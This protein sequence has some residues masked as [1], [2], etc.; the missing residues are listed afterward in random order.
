MSGGPAPHEPVESDRADADE[1]PVPT[2]H[3]D[4]AALI[5][6]LADPVFV[7][8]T[9]GRLRFL[10]AAVGAVLG[11]EP[12]E[13]IGRSVGEVVHQDDLALVVSSLG[14]VQGKPTGT[15][16]EVRVRNAA[17][18]WQWLEV[19]GADRTGVP[20]VDGVVCVARDLTQ[21]RM[22]EVAAGDVTRFQQVVQHAPSITLLLDG[23]GVV[24]STNGAFTR[25]LGHD[26]SLVVGQRLAVFAEPPNDV[27]LQGTIDACA[28]TGDSATVEVPMCRS[29]PRAE[30]VPVR[31][32]IIDLL[33][34]PVVAGIVVTGHDISELDDARRALEHLVRHD[35]LTGL[36]NRALLRDRLDD[37]LAVGRGFTVLFVDLD[38]FKPVNDLLGHETGDDVLRMVADR[39]QSV[40]R[41]GDVVARVGGDEFVMVALDVVEHADATALA[42]RVERRLSEPY[43]MSVGPVRVGA[44]VG[45][46]AAREGTNADHL[47]A[48]ADASM[49]ATKDA[50][51]RGVAGPQ[52][53]QRR[54]LDRGR[55][56]AEDLAVGI[57]RGEV[58]A[59]L[60]PI[61]DVRTGR[62]VMLEALARWRH[63][64]LGLLAPRAFIDLA[65][66]TGLDVALGEAVLRSACATIRRAGD[67]A[68]EV[69]LSV[70]M[71]VGELTDV[72]ARD[73]VERTLREFDLPAHRLV[74]E[75][76]EDA[77]GTSGDSGVGT[78]VTLLALD[79]MG[80]RLCL[81]D[82]G[83]GVSSLTTV[84]RFPLSVLKVDGTFVR[85][86]THRHQDRA[87]VASVVAV[88]AALGVAVVAEAVESEEQLHFLAGLGCP[89]VQGH[90]VCKPLPPDDAI[91]WLRGTGSD[92]ALDA[93]GRPR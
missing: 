26:P 89:L 72:A 87:V 13:W 91:A 63:P 29:D 10:N 5:D 12:S 18:E 85:G 45:I 11:W 76:G 15:P 67:A 40:S 4:P 50:K 82:F 55:R 92:V 17:G 70:N 14:T 81:D 59:H 38:R 42:A 43:L 60:Q 58:D 32:Q 52:T 34:D 24:T 83:T 8:D 22:W 78:E 27:I 30:P 20:G 44:S 28:H 21:R 25:L 23:N 90:H 7:V 56:L 41:P 31:F 53:H 57:A 19:I 64:D 66:Y 68:S 48:E 3:W 6:A 71:S 51:R 16:I 37:L 65:E 79:A 47:L 33:D 75:V 1:P 74:V 86:M 69:A 9:D 80:A 36:A 62:T 54:A 49:Y 93:A 35:V 2:A 73:R 61:V 88:G 77:L 84:R 39:L 46:A